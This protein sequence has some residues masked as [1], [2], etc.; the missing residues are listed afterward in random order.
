MVLP[1]SAC[2]RRYCTANRIGPMVLS[3]DRNRQRR[4]LLENFK[5]LVALPHS[6]P[7]PTAAPSDRAQCECHGL[8][9]TMAA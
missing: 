8:G 5:R 2:I 3:D 4:A 1:R 6:I 9:N 7:N